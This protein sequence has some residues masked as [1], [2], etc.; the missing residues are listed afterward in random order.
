MLRLLVDIRIS[1]PH[2]AT[3]KRGFV[4]ERDSNKIPM[5]GINK[6]LNIIVSAAIVSYWVMNKN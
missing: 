2:F 4:S 3:S 5:W 6:S 1:N